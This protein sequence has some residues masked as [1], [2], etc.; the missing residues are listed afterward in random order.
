MTT[1]F[2]TYVWPVVQE[3]A[4]KLSDIGAYYFYFSMRWALRIVDYAKSY[5][6]PDQC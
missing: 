2:A 3:V 4:T 1:A 5:V 6:A